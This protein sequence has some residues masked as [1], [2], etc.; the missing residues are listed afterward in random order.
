MSLPTIVNYLV[1]K[2]QWRTVPSLQAESI[3]GLGSKNYRGHPELHSNNLQKKEIHV[4]HLKQ[5]S[6][7]INKVD[8]PKLL[9]I[10]QIVEQN[11]NTESRQ[12]G[13]VI[14]TRKLDYSQTGEEFVTM[15]CSTSNFGNTKSILVYNL[16]Y[17][18]CKKE[19]FVDSLSKKTSI[20]TLEPID[21]SIIY[22]YEALVEFT[23]YLDM[24]KFRAMYNLVLHPR[25]QE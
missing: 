6:A 24:Q 9:R 12:K 17:K 2:F 20:N 10:I 4:K 19:H 22:E 11:L 7:V 18:L 1:W 16:V 21:F 23:C 8:R 3:S 13:T 14:H 15:L 5:I 25:N